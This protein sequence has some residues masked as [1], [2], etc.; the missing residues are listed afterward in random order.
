[1][2]SSRSAVASVSLTLQVESD[3]IYNA[4]VNAVFSFLDPLT[5]VCRNGSPY[6][7]LNTALLVSRSVSHKG[8]IQLTSPGPTKQLNAYIKLQRPYRTYVCIRST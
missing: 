3:S 1:M 2:F 7:S 5:G 6:W 8:L 4:S